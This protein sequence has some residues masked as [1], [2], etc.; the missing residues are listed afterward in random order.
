MFKQYTK[1][2][3]LMGFTLL[4][5]AA[6]SADQVKIDSSVLPSAATARVAPVP[7]DKRMGMTWGKYGSDTVTG[8]LQVGCQAGG[9]DCNAY[10]GD[11]ACKTKL[12]VLCKKKLSLNQPVSF[13]IPFDATHKWSGNVVAT[14]PAISPQANGL[15]T[16]ADVD[17]YCASE[18][19]AGWLAAEFHDGWGWNF[20]AYGNVGKAKRFWVDINDQPNANC[21]T[22]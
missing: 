6:F 2:V 3:A 10:T 4:S 22:R 14:T 12:P 11:T 19:G 21:W 13:S 20:T 17:K 15:S 18:F 9:K 1:L 8:V 7:A 16:L 5:A